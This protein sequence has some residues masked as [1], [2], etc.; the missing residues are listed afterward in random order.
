MEARN[1]LKARIAE[2]RAAIVAENISYS[3]LAEL[4]EIGETAPELLAGDGM[5]Q[6][7][8][9]LPEFDESGAPLLP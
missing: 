2:I 3:E 9:G 1:D 5:L 8:A 7:W 6:E 4:Q